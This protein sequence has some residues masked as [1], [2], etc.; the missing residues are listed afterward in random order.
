MPSEEVP[1]TCPV[2]MVILS[3]WTARL[4]NRETETQTGKQLKGFQH[5]TGDLNKDEERE[6]AHS[7]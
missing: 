3:G 4:V 2:A 5:Q 7:T 6:R 1:A